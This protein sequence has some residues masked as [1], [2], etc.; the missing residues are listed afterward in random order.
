MPTKKGNSSLRERLFF[1]R[2]RMKDMQCSD[3]PSTS[4]GMLILQYVLEM[5]NTTSLGL[6]GEI[7]SKIPYSS[8]SLSD[9]TQLSTRI[10]VVG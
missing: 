10:A 4:S 3:L 5:R 8:S 2:S 7:A 6:D 1:N 9:N